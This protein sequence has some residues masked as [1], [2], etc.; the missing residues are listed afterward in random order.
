MSGH[1]EQSETQHARPNHDALRRVLD[2]IAGFLPRWA[3][4]RNAE[5]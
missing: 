1:E 2:L 5:E 3:E 4:Y